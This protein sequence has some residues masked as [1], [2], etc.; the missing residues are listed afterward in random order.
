MVLTALLVR[1]IV[2]A[3]RDLNNCAGGGIRF[4]PFSF[5]KFYTVIIIVNLFLFSFNL[6]ALRS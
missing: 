5:Q 3:N 1:T 2:N 4:V 6:K